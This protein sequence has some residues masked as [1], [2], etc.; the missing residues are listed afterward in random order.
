MPR[1]FRFFNE[2]GIV[3]QLATAMFEARLPKGI[4]ISHFSVLSHLIRVQDGRT[5]V[6]L[7]RAFQVAKTTMTH[8]LAGL[9]KRELIEMRPNPDDARSKRV[10]LTDQGRTFRQD[11]IMSM[12]PDFMSLAAQY[13]VERLDAMLP[14]LE[15]LRKIM[16]AARD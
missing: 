8:T 5:P 7:A 12:A 2:V 1:Y 15:A 13:D 16:D 11:A 14:H 4:L 10:W 6:E 9:E 3:N